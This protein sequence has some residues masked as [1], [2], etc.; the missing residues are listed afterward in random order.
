MEC[1]CPT[2]YV[3]NGIGPTGC[4]LSSSPFNPCAPNPCVNGDCSIN[5]FTGEYICTCKDNFQGR[6]CNIATNNPCTTNPCRNGG[7]CLNIRGR[8]FHCVCKGG[9]RG[10]LCETEAPGINN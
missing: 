2:G 1:I 6:N 8:T 7:T 3:G 9:F 4:I 5:N 10:T